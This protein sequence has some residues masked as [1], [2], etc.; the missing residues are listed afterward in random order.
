MAEE[1]D[2]KAQEPLPSEPYARGRHKKYPFP[3]KSEVPG[4]MMVV[5]DNK[6]DDRG[7]HLIVPFTRAVVQHELHEL[8]VTDEKGARPGAEVNRVGTLGFFE[9]NRTGLLAWGDE[10]WINDRLVGEVIGFDLTHFPNHLNVVCY[11][12]ERLTG[13]E[14]GLAVDDPVRFKLPEEVYKRR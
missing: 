7:L 11:S 13:I 9:I 8:M 6:H 5:A 10:L 14:M 12:S 1:K 3:A 2:T 4:R